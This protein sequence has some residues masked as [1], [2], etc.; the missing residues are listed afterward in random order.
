LPETPFAK[1]LPGPRRGAASSL[2][3]AKGGE[4]LTELYT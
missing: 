2:L 1:G 3:S 4:A